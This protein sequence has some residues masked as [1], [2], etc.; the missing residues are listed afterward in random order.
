MCL[1]ALCVGGLLDLW[2][3]GLGLRVVAV[4]RLSCRFI[5]LWLSVL[6]ACVSCAFGGI[7]CRRLVLTE[8]MQRERER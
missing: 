4:L 5:L 3:C 7:L 1:G 6:V 8:K 2:L